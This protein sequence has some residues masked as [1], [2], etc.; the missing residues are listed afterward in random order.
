LYG[1]Q[2]ESLKKFII[3]KHIKNIY[4]KNKKYWLKRL[5]QTLVFSL[6]LRFNLKKLTFNFSKLEL[7]F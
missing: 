2:E 5:W 6:K 1:D 7:A 3:T 4:Q